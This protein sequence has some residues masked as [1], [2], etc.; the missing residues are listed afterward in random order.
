MISSHFSFYFSD[1]QKNLFKS[2]IH[3]HLDHHHTYHFIFVVQ[4]STIII[5]HQFIMHYYP[6]LTIHHHIINRNIFLLILT[7]MTNMVIV[8]VPLLDY[9]HFTTILA[10]ITFC[11]V[12]LFSSL[13][14]LALP[15]QL[16]ITQ[17][18]TLF[19]CIPSNHHHDENNVLCHI[20]SLHH[21][22]DHHHIKKYSIHSTSSSST[23]LFRFMWYKMHKCFISRHATTEFLIAY[24]RNN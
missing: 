4:E 23:Y 15:A 18:F 5:T 21:Q 9:I 13:P 6:S 1:I 7:T 16:N 2:S 12:V 14:L 24:M 19:F 3:F 20:T 8:H 22:H 17:K 10:L 11:S